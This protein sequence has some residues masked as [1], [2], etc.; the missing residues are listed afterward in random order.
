M[1]GVQLIVAIGAGLIVIFFIV[2]FWRVVLGLG[3][4]G[5]LAIGALCI[6]GN[7]NCPIGR[8]TSHTGSVGNNSKSNASNL[9]VINSVYQHLRGKT[10]TDYESRTRTNRVPCS[11]QDDD[12]DPIGKRNPNMG[13]CRDTGGYGYGYK[14]E[15][16]TQNVPVKRQCP[17][18]P[19]VNS[20]AW[21]VQQ[22]GNDKWTVYSHQGSWTVEKSGSGFRIT[23]HQK[24]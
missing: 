23:P 6:S 17:T 12:F 3:V 7:L 22:S 9:E 15:T 1:N 24:C 21:S 8:R 5:A 16:I 13:K 19:A 11:Q 10:Y 4:L 14:T 20:T 2:K 18:P